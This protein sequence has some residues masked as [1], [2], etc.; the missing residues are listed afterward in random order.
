VAEAGD[1]ATQLGMLGDS[2]RTAR[3]GFAAAVCW[4]LLVQPAV[5]APAGGPQWSGTSKPLRYRVQEETAPGALVGNV[6]EDS[7]LRRRYDAG[8]L[9][10][11]RFR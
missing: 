6:L 1:D 9:R 2:G 8:V 11:L 3:P 10:L 4:W 7:G 5:A